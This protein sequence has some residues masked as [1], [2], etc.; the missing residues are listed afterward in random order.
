MKTR[1]SQTH[2]NIPNAKRVF[3]N[4]NSQLLGAETELIH[5]FRLVVEP[6]E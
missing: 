4:G 3:E 5:R 6:P 1:E 2:W